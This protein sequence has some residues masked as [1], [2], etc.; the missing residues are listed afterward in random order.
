LFERLKTAEIHGRISY[1]EL[2]AFEPRG[3]CLRID[4]NREGIFLNDD[5]IAP[6]VRAKGLDP[7]K[8]PVNN[9]NYINFHCRVVVILL[10][11][12]INIQEVGHQNQ[13]IGEKFST[14]CP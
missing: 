8:L 14:A 5:L 1:W 6:L 3:F 10:D 12:Q 2:S 13:P 4:D 9:I 11:D 7:G